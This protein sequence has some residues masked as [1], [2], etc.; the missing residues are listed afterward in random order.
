MVAPIGMA[1]VFRLAPPD[2]MGAVMGTLGVP[3]LITSKIIYKKR[4]VHHT[5]I[6]SMSY[7]LTS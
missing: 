5:C 1:M 7:F 2:K 6:N 3:M 4:V